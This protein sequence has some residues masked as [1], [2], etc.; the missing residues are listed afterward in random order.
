MAMPNEMTPALSSNVIEFGYDPEAR[1]LYVRF[2]GGALYQYQGVP[3]DIYDGLM[4][5]DS[6]GVFV[7][8]AIKGY[9]QYSKIG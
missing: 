2:K 7:N 8:M 9:F 5:S 4:N 3:Q 6:K 1:E